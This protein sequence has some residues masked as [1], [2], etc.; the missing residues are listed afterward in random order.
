M[1]FWFT[2]TPVRWKV[3]TSA[4]S[5]MSQAV[6]LFSFAAFFAPKVVNLNENSSKELAIFAFVSG[7]LLLFAGVIMSEKGKEYVG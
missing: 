2:L 3:L 1:R 7:L 6:I 5:N 4:F